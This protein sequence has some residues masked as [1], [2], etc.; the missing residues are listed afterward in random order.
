MPLDNLLKT[1]CNQTSCKSLNAYYA[2]SCLLNICSMCFYVLLT[3]TDIY[4]ALDGSFMEW[5]VVPVVSSIG[6]G[7]LTQQQGHHLKTTYRTSAF[8]LYLAK[9]HKIPGAF[10]PPG[11]FCRYSAA[12]V[13]HSACVDGTPM[14]LS[15]LPSLV[16][17]DAQILLYF[18]H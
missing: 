17:K 2:H 3:Y 9:K 5:C 10:L 7:P 13:R 11:R 12:T 4:L 1:L 14:G 16:K 8:T 15:I 6:V 18:M